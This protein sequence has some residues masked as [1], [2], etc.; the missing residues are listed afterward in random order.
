MKYLNLSLT[1]RGT[2]GG[3]FPPP[4]PFCNQ[5]GVEML[6]AHPCPIQIT[7]RA[8]RG[9]KFYIRKPCSECLGTGK[10]VRKKTSWFRTP[11][12]VED[13]QILKV[14][15]ESQIVRVYIKV[16]KSDYFQKEGLNVHSDA[17]ISF[18]QA[19]LGGS[20]NIKGLYED[21]VVHIPSCTS[22]HSVIK[23]EN[24]GWQNSFLKGDH[25]VHLKIEIPK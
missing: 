10:V 22:S 8:C 13:G 23:I 15:I 4:C 24:K 19:L 7:C 21:L 25:F 12:G 14:K 3:H 6:S 16:L 9:T 20:I 1:G 2:F 17:T 5:T 18:S 11:A